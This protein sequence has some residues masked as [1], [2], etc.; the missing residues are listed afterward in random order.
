LDKDEQQRSSPMPIYSGPPLSPGTV[1]P[2][3]AIR[4]DHKP[5]ASQ[6]RRSLPCR[7]R[8]QENRDVDVR[9][10]LAATSQ[11]GGAEMGRKLG[12]DL[13]LYAV[14]GVGTRLE[15]VPHLTYEPGQSLSGTASRFVGG[16]YGSFSTYGS[17]PGRFGLG[18]K[19][20]Y[21]LVKS[22]P[23][24]SLWNLSSTL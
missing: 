6:E 22:S 5:R 21:R 14:V 7:T 2:P 10:Q 12:A 16:T 3:R 8:L 4:A 17:S 18:C 23:S 15:S 13:V 11:P 24:K 20:G 9:S 19:A 1:D